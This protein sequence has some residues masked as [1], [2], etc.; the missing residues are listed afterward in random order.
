MIPKN[1][2][3]EILFLARFEFKMIIFQNK[4]SEIKFGSFMIFYLKS[5]YFSKNKFCKSNFL[6]W[7]VSFQYFVKMIFR[8]ENI[9]YISEI[10]TR[11]VFLNFS[12]KTSQKFCF[13]RKKLIEI[14]ESKQ[15]F[16]LTSEFFET[17]ITLSNRNKTRHHKRNFRS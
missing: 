7:K 14:F 8:L 10:L 16:R 3:S 11:K 9:S 5:I 6:N 15:S 13:S 17:K 4:K 2:D 1:L 12:R